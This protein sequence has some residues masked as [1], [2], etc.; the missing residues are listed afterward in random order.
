MFLKLSRCREILQIETL[1]NYKI[2]NYGEFRALYRF[3]IP[4]EQL[5]QQGERKMCRFVATLIIFGFAI[6]ANATVIWDESTKSSI[7]EWTRSRVD[8]GTLSTGV[9]E[10]KGALGIGMPWDEP[11]T[12]YTDS[13]SFALAEGYEL[14]E[15]NYTFSISSRGLHDVWVYL[16]LNEKDSGDLAYSQV[17][18]A[19]GTP[20]LQDVVD[21]IATSQ[22]LLYSLTFDIADP[23][24]SD[25]EAQARMDYSAE[26][27]V[28][29]VESMPEPTTLALL[30]IG[31]IGLGAMRKDKHK[32]IYKTI[33]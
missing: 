22:A 7:P 26:F 11:W 33:S 6:T 16:N 18:K 1:N 17:Y 15:V 3:C 5:G 13:I 28:R 8:L 2:L 10:V 9:T 29:A 12:G 20:R 31:G 21:H 19:R 27:I 23:R 24:F 25:R 4:L 14:I 32:K 30:G